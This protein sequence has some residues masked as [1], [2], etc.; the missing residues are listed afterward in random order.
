M[1]MMEEEE[2]MWLEPSKLLMTKGGDVT[3]P[4]H[5]DDGG[6]DN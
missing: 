2:E 5:F 1:M 3:E 4:N 6:G